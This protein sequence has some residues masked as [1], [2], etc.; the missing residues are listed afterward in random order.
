MLGA[1]ANM[2]ASPETQFSKRVATEIFRPARFWGARALC[3][4]GGTKASVEHAKDVA[5]VLNEILSPE[6]KRY[7]NST[8]LKLSFLK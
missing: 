1:E 8:N 4:P 3:E 7:L 5:F 6:N 2:E